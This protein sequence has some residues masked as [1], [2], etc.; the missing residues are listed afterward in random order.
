MY[1][2]LFNLEYLNSLKTKGGLNFDCKIRRESSDPADLFI[3]HVGAIDNLAFALKKAAQ[4]YEDNLLKQMV[5][6]RY[7]SF[8]TTELGKQIEKGKQ[9]YSLFRQCG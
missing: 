2:I 5:D 3:G 6:Q 7:L 8:H 1:W 9:R 4:I